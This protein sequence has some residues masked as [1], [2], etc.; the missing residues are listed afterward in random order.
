MAASDYENVIICE[1]EV[2]EWNDTLVNKRVSVCIKLPSGIDGTADDISIEVLD[3]IVVVNFPRDRGFKNPN[4]L[5]KM[6]AKHAFDPNSSMLVGF[7]AAIM[8]KNGNSKRAKQAQSPMIVHLP[9]PCE[10]ELCGF[11][12]P[13]AS[14]ISTD[15]NGANLETLCGVE[16]IFRAGCSS[17]RYLTFHL[18]GER[19]KYNVATTV[20][21]ED[22][23]SS[24][25][26]STPPSN[27]H[28]RGFYRGKHS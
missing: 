4:F 11:D 19:N 8:A 9:R 12:V 23:F 6:Y 15:Y 1:H 18:M 22:F 24:A 10:R 13:Y 21:E 28:K 7:R 3:Q 14:K 2:W 17:S 27:A 26:V 20:A 5:G 25:S 16:A